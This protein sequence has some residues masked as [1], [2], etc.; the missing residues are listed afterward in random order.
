MDCQATYHTVATNIPIISKS[1]SYVLPVG[2][3]GAKP[4]FKTKHMIK[5]V[6]W[7]PEG[8]WNVLFYALADKKE[9][10]VETVHKQ[11]F[12]AL[13]VCKGCIAYTH[14]LITHQSRREKKEKPEGCH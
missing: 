8:R 4:W 1:G 11:A 7:D 5:F 2:G 13:Q 3:G 12:I 14:V 6:I 9:W 10:M